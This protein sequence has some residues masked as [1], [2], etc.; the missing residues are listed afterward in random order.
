MCVDPIATFLTDT[1]GCC[2]G[3]NRP[4][5]LDDA[6]EDLL[7]T[8]PVSIMTPV[9]ETVVMDEPLALPFTTAASA[10]GVCSS[11]Q[12]AEFDCDIAD[13]VVGV[14]VCR[15]GATTCVLASDTV[16][17]DT[18]GCCPGDSRVECLEDGDGWVG[19]DDDGN[20]DDGEGDNDDM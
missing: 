20:D 1:C 16:T 6:A 19:A 2:P 17:T 3:D 18:C 11:F 7:T 10:N 15:G 4:E 9:N 13:D 5:C 12:L 8:P 14:Y